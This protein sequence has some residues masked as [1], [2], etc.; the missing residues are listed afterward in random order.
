MFVKIKNIFLFLSFLLPFAFA[1][2]VLGVRDVPERL[3]H[4]RTNPASVVPENPSTGGSRSSLL[5]M[6]VV[7]DTKVKLKTDYIK[8]FLAFL[9]LNNFRALSVSENA[10]LKTKFTNLE[11]ILSDESDLRSWTRFIVEDDRDEDFTP[12]EETP[13]A[14][15]IDLKI[16]DFIEYLVQHRAFMAGD[17]QFLHDSDF[18]G[19]YDSIDEVLT[20]IKQS[21]LVNGAAEVYSRSNAATLSVR[22]VWALPFF[23]FVL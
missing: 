17:L 23:V 22:F 4:S 13:G 16:D 20:E 2:N 1:T 18:D 8:E 19:D 11:R 5:L 15:S 12:V 6:G 3:V 9:S 14:E 7:P 10:P 21:Y